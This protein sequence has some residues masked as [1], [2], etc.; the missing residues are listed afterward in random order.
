MP[1]TISIDRLV[2]LS[3]NFHRTFHPEILK[4]YRDSRR[5]RQYFSTVTA[6]KDRVIFSN[7][8][9]GEVAQGYQKGWTPKGDLIITPEEYIL[10]Y[11]KID[12][13]IDPNE[14]RQTYLADYLGGATPEENEIIR[15]FYQDMVVRAAEDTDNALM[16]GKYVPPTAGTAG[17]A[18]EMVDGLKETTKKFVDKGQIIP[19][20]IGA[21]DESNACQALRE[22][23]KQIP[24]RYR[25]NPKL[26]CYIFDATWDMYRECYDMTYG[27]LQTNNNT[28]TR[29]HNTSC[30]I[31][32]LPYGGVSN[33]VLFTMDKN[34][35]LLDND[36][37]NLMKF[38]VQKDKRVLNFMQ[39][40]AAGIGFVV[41]GRADQ[42]ESSYVW[43]NDF[44]YIAEDGGNGDG[45]GDG[46]GG[47]DGE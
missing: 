3:L 10:R 46:N 27:M 11:M 37:A 25:H 12:K 34:I 23:W 43:C 32:V 36:P 39:D 33:M 47:G 28:P 9:V 29:I 1:T 7:S 14:L 17:N 44:D 5:L 13:E 16:N 38:T 45:D 2:E 8:E 30:E 4:K 22:L 31:V 21:F 35:R 24:E 18:L 6:V 20:E 42:P 19:F 26:R 15:M 40:W 41:V